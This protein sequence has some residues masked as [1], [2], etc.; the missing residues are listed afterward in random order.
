VDRLIFTFRPRRRGA[1]ALFA[2]GL[3]GVASIAAADAIAN[4][5]I[6]VH[7]QTIAHS[8]RAYGQVEPIA[9]IQVRAVNPGTLSGLRVVPG[10]AV[11]EG[12]VLARIGGPRM[13]SLLT[14]RAQTLRGAQS[15]E[16]AASRALEIVQRQ[17]AVQ[18]ATRQAVNAAR[19]ELAAA[20]AAAR[21]ADAQLREAQD[22]QTVRAP[23]AGTVIEV[24]AADGEQTTAGQ[25]LLT[26]QPAGK[27][28]IR[29]AYYGA[30]AALLHVGM[31]G[32]FQPSG[33]GE[34]IPVRIAAISSSIAADGGLGVGLVPTSPA[35]PRWWISGQ[36]GTLTL[37]GPSRAMVEVPTQALILDRGR[38]W[39]LVHT[40]Q[41]NK[42]QEVAPGPA[43]GWQTAIAS[44]LQPGQQVVVTDAFLQYHRGIAR[45][46]TAP[47]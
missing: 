34:T 47:N 10:S 27:L 39:V 35:P 40:A 20:Q 13:E 21:T 36:W 19:S 45:S 23:A 31:T 26:L 16:E 28:W 44:G 18:L 5:F 9:V 30:D 17:L 1:I 11:T 38:W 25:T 43:H 15:R 6:T 46:Y 42:P 4:D 22:L 41:G 3:L 12:E 29:A 7:A 2:A 37:T 14:A 8:L 32:H 24:Q 33:D